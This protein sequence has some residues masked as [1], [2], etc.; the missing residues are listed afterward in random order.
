[1]YVCWCPCDGK[2]AL[3]ETRG[4]ANEQRTE[5]EDE[6]RI[7]KHTG[8][9]ATWKSS[10]SRQDDLTPTSA[11]QG[12]AWRWPQRMAAPTTVDNSITQPLNTKKVQR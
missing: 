12:E 1:M 6:R 11:K 9:K 10:R 4:K 7:E 3:T 2:F 8:D 5:E